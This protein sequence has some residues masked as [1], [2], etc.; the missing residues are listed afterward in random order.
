MRYFR[1]SDGW[2]LTTLW[3]IG[4]PADREMLNRYGDMFNHA[5]FSD[6]EVKNGMARLSLAELAQMQG[7]LYAATTDGKAFVDKHF[8]RKEGHIVAMLHVIDMLIEEP[9]PME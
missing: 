4:K 2:L 7:D 3:A 9:G 5:I 8:D 6:E 1:W